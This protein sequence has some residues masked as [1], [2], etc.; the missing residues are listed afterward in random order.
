MTNVDGNIEI[1]GTLAISQ[2]N[3]VNAVNLTGTPGTGYAAAMTQN[4][5]AEA[6]D[7]VSNN[8]IIEAHSPGVAG[9]SIATTETFTAVTNIFDAATLGTTQ[10]GVDDAAFSD[11]RITSES[12]TQDTDTTSS[13]ELRSD[14]QVPDFVRTNVSAA[15]ETPIEMSYGAF[16]D[17]LESALLSPAWTADVTAITAAATI[18]AD[19]TDNS[20]ND[21]GS[22]MATY[23]VNQWIRVSGF[24]TAANNGY[25]KI[26]SVAAGKIVVQGN[27][28]VTEAAGPSV[29]IKQGGSITNGIILKSYTLEKEFTDLT[30]EFAL[31]KGMSVEQFTMS[32]ASDAIMT[33]SFS[34]IGKNAVSDNFTKSSSKAAVASNSV[35]NGIDNVNSILESGEANNATNFEL[36]LTNN[37]R[38][39]QQIGTLGAI[40]VGT[41]TVDV[42]GTLNQYFETKALFDKYLNF[43][44]TSLAMVIVD[45]SN[46]AYVVDFP[47][48]KITSGERVSGGINQDI[49][50]ALEFGAFLDPTENI[51][52]RIARISA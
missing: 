20:F 2:Q 40:S 31:Y 15:G 22:G 36:T 45:A 29:T 49:I 43:T 27:T 10:A 39:R 23:G 12:L 13:Q 7:F 34:W 46:N 6:G 37:L 48:V 14:R 16:D 21:S 42:T 33:G 4:Q 25:F 32:V 8:S 5:S 30:N 17:L 9:N 51:T 50:A 44:T 52:F 18:S 1:G 19:A 47:S 26:V 35:M 38:A 11:M 28:L 41:G 3:L 24:G